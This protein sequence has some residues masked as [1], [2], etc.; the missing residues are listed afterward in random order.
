LRE[1]LAPRELN[2]KLPRAIEAICLKAMSQDRSVRY[3]SAQD[4]AAEITRFLD[5]L[6]VAAYRET[7]FERIGHWMGRHRFLIFLL[8]AYLLMRIIVLLAFNR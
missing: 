2:P 3:S 5:A 6:P 4:L 8:M 7:V 1:P